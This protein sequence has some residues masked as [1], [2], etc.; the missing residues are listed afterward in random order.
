[1]EEEGETKKRW[2]VEIKRGATSS[3]GEE[4][5][6]GGGLLKGESE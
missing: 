4:S 5:Q 2:R 3:D 1:M 6:G